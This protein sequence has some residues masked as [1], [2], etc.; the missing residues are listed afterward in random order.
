MSLITLCIR[1]ALA[2][3]VV[4]L[5]ALYFMQ[6]GML[7]PASIELAGPPTGHHAGYDVEPWHVNGDYAGYLVT[8]SGAQPRGTFMVFHGNAETAENK[9]PLAEIFVRDGYRVVV[10]EYPGQ[11]S[12]QGKRTM[13]AALAASRESLGAA[14]AQ[15]PG[16]LYLVG[17]SL[18]AGM[19]AQAIKG[20]EASVAGVALITPWDSLA[21][22]AS[23]H[24]PIFPVRWMLHDPFDSVA[25]LGRYD[26]PL[27]VIGA[28]Q[29]T[30]I[31]ITHAKRLAD[32]HSGAH[33]ML[34]P[35]ANHEDWF[36]AMND[37]HW[38]RVLHWMQAD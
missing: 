3:Y 32:S 11:G 28:Q 17:E 22:V 15:W 7:L 33:L 14:R 25:A 27:V 13:L 1:I 29:D 26:G 4:T 2:A 10:V 30:L 24:Y 9:L 35:D 6:D 37:A 34:L 16:R 20:N 21:S 12:R 8:P 23:T 38:H 36:G 31:P 5:V 18:G 19:A